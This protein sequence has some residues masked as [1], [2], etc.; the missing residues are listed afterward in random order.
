M[1]GL[2]EGRVAIRAES[3]SGGIWCGELDLQP[4]GVDEPCIVLER[5]AVLRG[6]VVL[7]DAG[8]GVPCMVDVDA[9]APGGRKRVSADASGR[10]EVKGLSAA[11]RV[12]WS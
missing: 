1:R 7:E 11:R 10:F 5:G 3:R 9:G 6:Q 8:R 2:L 12:P 4:A